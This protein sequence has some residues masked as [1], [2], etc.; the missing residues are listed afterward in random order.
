MWSYIN[1]PASQCGVVELSVD[2]YIKLFFSFG[3]DLSQMLKHTE[4][5]QS[6]VNAAQF[7]IEIKHKQV[8]KAL[9]RKT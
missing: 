3:I 8:L 4:M 7:H 5:S 9:E 2:K 6:T 1:V